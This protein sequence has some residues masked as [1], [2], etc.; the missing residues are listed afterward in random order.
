VGWCE[1]VNR[2]SEITKRDIHSL[3]C[4]GIIEEGLFHPIKKGFNYFGLL[5]EIE[6]LKSLYDLK[7]MPSDDPRYPDAEGDIIQ[8]TINNDDY[9]FCWVFE[10]ERFQLKNGSDDIY[11]KFICEIFHPA[12]RYEEGFWRDYLSETNRLLKN[13]GYEIYPVKKISNR[14]VYDW[15]IFN[16]E[17]SKMFIPY[18]QRNAESKNEKLS[19]NNKARYQI[20]QLIEKYNESYNTTNE[21]G[22]Q[23]GTSRSEETFLMI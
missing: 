4:N 2:I 21:T 11:L 3:F 18:S 13:D 9:P 22:W 15:R 8:H 19:I 23:Y 1:L 12:V 7:N 17:E 14:E 5:E 10:D 20:Y 16:I 6:F